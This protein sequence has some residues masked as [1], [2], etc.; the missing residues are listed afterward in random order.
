MPQFSLTPCKT[1]ELKT[2]WETV[3][4]DTRAVTDAFF[5]NAFYPDGC[6][7]A[8]RDGKAVSALYLLPVTLADK[9]GFYLYAAA[10]LPDYRGAGLMAAL[11]EEALQYA[12]HQADF[13]Y[14]C[15][16]EDS[17]YGYY[18]RFGFNHILY[19]KFTDENT[20]VRITGSDEMLA[21]AQ[22]VSE[23]P[24]FCEGVYRYAACI[25]CEMYE[26][27]AVRF[28]GQFAL[29]VSAAVG[30]ARPYGVLCPLNNC[31]FSENIFAFLTMN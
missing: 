10:T 16:A 21:K 26:N 13:V 4:G 30:E 22:Q 15:P 27:A 14:L 18:R 23:A 28:D 29:P 9:K 19:A 5:R 3:F 20:A 8:E 17:L 12:K 7:F 11:I 24:V 31:N 25:G 1:E 2:L 6:F